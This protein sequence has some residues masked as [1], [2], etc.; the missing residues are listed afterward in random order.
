MDTS[1]PPIETSSSGSAPWSITIAVLGAAV[2]VV[3]AFFAWWYFTQEPVQEQTSVTELTSS[4]DA[5]VAT[6]SVSI[7]TTA[8]PLKSATPTVNPTEKTNPFNNEYQ[9]PFQ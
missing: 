7:P 5:L 4:L 2:L 8:N 1:I 3:I 6:T 9:N